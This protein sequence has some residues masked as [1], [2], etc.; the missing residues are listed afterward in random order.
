ME[1]QLQCWGGGL[2]FGQSFKDP[3]G[4]GGLD[5][6]GVEA[7][8]LGVRFTPLDLSTNRSQRPLSVLLDGHEIGGLKPPNFPPLFG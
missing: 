1:L 6:W 7:F 3:K 4:R 8:I 2:T 5:L